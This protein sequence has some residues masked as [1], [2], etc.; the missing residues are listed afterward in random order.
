MKFL[1]TLLALLPWA[2]LILAAPIDLAK[3]DA[4]PDFG[5]YGDYAPPPGGYGEY[6]KPP[7]GYD[8]YP[9]PEGGYGSYG[10]YKRE[11]IEEAPK[12]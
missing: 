7:G 9:A 4:S 5:S 6:P 12:E 8:T 10:E 11:S 2:A 1:L 3:K